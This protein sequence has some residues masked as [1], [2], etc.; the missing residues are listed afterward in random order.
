MLSTRLA[1]LERNAIK[2]IC[3]EKDNGTTGL[4]DIW[5]YVSIREMAISFCGLLSIV[6]V[7]G[8]LKSDPNE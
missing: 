1:E 3:V 7:V 8:Y 2:A 6:V 5:I 4:F